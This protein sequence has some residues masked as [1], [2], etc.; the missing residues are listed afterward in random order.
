MLSAQDQLTELVRRLE[1]KNH[2]FATDPLLV[3]EQMQDETGT[4]LH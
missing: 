1:A 3:T 2:L 4:P